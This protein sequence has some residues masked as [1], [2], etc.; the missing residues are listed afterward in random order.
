MKKKTG[1]TRTS[2]QYNAVYEAQANERP[3]LKKGR[4]KRNHVLIWTSA[5]IS[6]FYPSSKKDKAI[7]KYVY[8]YTHV[9]SS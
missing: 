3:E 4:Q 8:V 9:N 2:Q 6:P 7:R 5:R 1:R